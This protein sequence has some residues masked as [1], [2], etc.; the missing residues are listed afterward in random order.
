MFGLSDPARVIFTQNTTAA[1]NLAIKG[2]LRRGERAVCSDMEHN[3]VFRPLFRLAG[4]GGISFDR[5]QTFSAVPERTD[6]MLLS[7]LEHA[8]SR[9]TRLVVCAHASN[10]CPA[11]LPLAAASIRTAVTKISSAQ[12]HGGCAYG[13]TFPCMQAGNVRQILTDAGIR[14]RQIFG[15]P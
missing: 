1:L 2:I 10:I 5:F 13:L 12:T 14:V 4:E 15:E 8:L 3:A 7:S 11:T 6:A 9:P